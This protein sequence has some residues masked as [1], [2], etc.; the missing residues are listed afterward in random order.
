[1]SRDR[2][3][4]LVMI[5]E[6]FADFGDYYGV[7]YPRPLLAAG[8]FPVLLPYLDDA[9][10]RREAI[11]RADGIVLAGGRDIDPAHYGRNEPHPNQ[12]AP[13]WELDEIE[14]DYARL[15]VEQAVPVLGICRGCQI[16]NVAFGGTLY[17]DLDEFP[18]GGAD[19]PGAKW[20]EWRALVAAT[21]ADE[22]RPAHPTHPVDIAAG[23]L[24]ASHL[25]VNADVD[26]YHHQAVAEV[27][28]GLVATAF[29]PHGAVEAIEMPGAPA[30]VLG[31]Q[32]ELHE[33]W[34]DDERSLG[35]WRAFVGAARER[36][37]ARA[38][39]PETLMP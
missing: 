12:L 8:A 35:I 28:R 10:D 17:G 29:A 30:F 16:L 26:S 33:E 24:L 9:D 19:H 2:Q 5:S 22:P 37:E 34:Q 32:W 38:N 18:H 39:D 6:G 11:A 1:M 21:L 20:A 31:V 15:A 14:F 4:P 13:Q 23:S 25:G 27:G 36:S 3:R 7:G